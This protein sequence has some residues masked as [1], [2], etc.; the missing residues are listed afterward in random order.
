MEVSEGHDI[1]IGGRRCVLITGQPPLL[2]G[3]PRAKKTTT[4]EALQAMEGDV[5]V[6]PWLHWRIGV[7][8]C[9]FDDGWDMDAGSLGDWQQRL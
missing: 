3:S 9:E 4:N 7:G 1:A 2:D 5:G 6:A 8:G